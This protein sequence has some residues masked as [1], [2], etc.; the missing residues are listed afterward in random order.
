MQNAQKSAKS[1]RLQW[2]LIHHET[3]HPV[4]GDV[5]KQHSTTKSN[6]NFP[7]SD[8]VRKEWKVTNTCRKRLALCGTPMAR[9]GHQPSE[10][11]LGEG[12]AGGRNIEACF[13]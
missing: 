3:T 7:F 5:W 12:S 9:T 6:T 2:E 8:A 4:S 13:L 10:I 1:R 11:S